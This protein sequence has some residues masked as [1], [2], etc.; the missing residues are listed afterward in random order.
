MD[1]GSLL[2][3]IG[4]VAA[5][6]MIYLLI[7]MV[8]PPTL[9]MWTAYSIW[10]QGSFMS[11]GKLIA[12]NACLALVIAI[13]MFILNNGTVFELVEV[14]YNVTGFLFLFVLLVVCVEGIW[15]QYFHILAKFKMRRQSQS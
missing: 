9:M 11:S 2:S 4:M 13:A 15:S 14:G 7:F 6:A 1:V 5:Q 8:L 12:I 3:H 10:K